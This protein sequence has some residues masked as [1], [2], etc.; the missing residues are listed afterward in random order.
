MSIYLNR[1]KDNKRRH[2]FKNREFKYIMLSWA[3]SSINNKNRFPLLD[4]YKI[5][6]FIYYQKTYT[7]KP[8]ESRTRIRN[9][10]IISG[11][12]RSSSRISRMSNLSLL[13]VTKISS[14]FPALTRTLK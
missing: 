4:V 5:N 14:R 6:K 2:L 11:K 1:L 7:T 8:N 9:N 13:E 10:C 3:L 12:R